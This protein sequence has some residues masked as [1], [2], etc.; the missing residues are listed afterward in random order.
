MERIL[1]V[2]GRIADTVI[3]LICD[4][5]S[6]VGL[7]KEERGEITEEHR[8]SYETIPINYNKPIKLYRYS[9]EYLYA[10]IFKKFWYDMLYSGIFDH[11]GEMRFDELRKMWYYTDGK[12]KVY[13]KE[14]YKETGPTFTEC[15]LKA[16]LYEVDHLDDDQPKKES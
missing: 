3:F 5:T 14:T 7:T 6:A 11:R 10:G 12:V 16:F 1:E 13:I 4:N 2:L 15:L 8:Q 9:P